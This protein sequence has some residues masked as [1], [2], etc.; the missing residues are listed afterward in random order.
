MNK[1]KKIFIL[2]LIQTF[3]VTNICFAQ[4]IGLRQGSDTLSPRVMINNDVLRP[5]F[6][7]RLS[8]GYLAGILKDYDP[9]VLIQSDG[10]LTLAGRVFVELSI[11]K[12]EFDSYVAPIFAMPVTQAEKDAIN[13]DDLKKIQ[14]MVEDLMLFQ[15]TLAP[16]F[17]EGNLPSV[18]ML[19]E[20]I[21]QANGLTWKYPDLKALQAKGTLSKGYE[22]GL[23]K[24]I[25]CIDFIIEHVNSV[26]FGAEEIEFDIKDLFEKEK[27]S[28]ILDVLGLENPKF[29][30]YR[31]GLNFVI[32]SLRNNVWQHSGQSNYNVKISEDEK[33]IIIVFTDYGKGFDIEILRQKAVDDRFLSYE[34]AEIASDAAIIDL[35]F[36]QSFIE[37]TEEGLA[38]GMGLMTCRQV[39]EKHFKGTITAENA[40]E[41]SGAV[42]KITIPKKKL[43]KF[44]YRRSTHLSLGAIIGIPLLI[45]TIYSMPGFVSGA[46]EQAILSI[47]ETIGINIV[48]KIDKLFKLDFKSNN[49]NFIEQAI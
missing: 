30:G 17:E 3:F 27:R 18:E 2:I 15:R 35:I 39:I 16:E 33:D 12:H 28:M 5:V 46:K 32:K 22:Y 24:G 42:F 38:H 13:K 48:S 7:F 29:F 36:R 40:K 43:E 1:L 44:I 23:E 31:S 26:V 19:N 9:S 21:M 34:T 49:L 20:I 6:S 37:T 10:D 47:E 4:E 8:E 25:S 41:H 14:I 45:G 11:I